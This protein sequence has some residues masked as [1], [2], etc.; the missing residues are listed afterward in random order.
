[1]TMKARRGQSGPCYATSSSTSVTHMNTT[2]F[3]AY[4]MECRAEGDTENSQKAKMALSA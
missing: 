2:D 4:D 1:M 3:R